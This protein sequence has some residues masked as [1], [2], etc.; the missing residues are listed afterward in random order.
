MT[1]LDSTPPRGSDRASL[2]DEFECEDTAVINLRGART[3]EERERLKAYR[4]RQRRD[5][6]AVDA[7]V[8]AVKRAGWKMIAAISLPILIEV[9][10]L[11]LD[12]MAHR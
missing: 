4:R 11:V 10:R 1:S 12:W 3:P 7:V 8:R 9:V 5:R 6:E 2:G